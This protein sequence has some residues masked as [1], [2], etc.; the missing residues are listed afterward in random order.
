MSEGFEP[1][2]DAG[3]GEVGVVHFVEDEADHAAVDLGVG[4]GE[5]V[6]VGIERAFE[7]RACRLQAAVDFA[8]S[9]AERRHRLIAASKQG[10]GLT[11]EVKYVLLKN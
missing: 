7:F 1:G 9:A 3:V 4:A 8:E 10:H 2:G 6:A 11:C 5:V